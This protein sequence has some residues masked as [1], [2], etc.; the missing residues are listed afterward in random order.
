M[1]SAETGAAMRAALT[2]RCPRCG[3]GRLLRGL[4]T[5]EPACLGC[6]T[7]LSKHMAGDGGPYVLILVLGHLMVA[8]A[9]A[10][11]AAFAPPMWLHLTF[12]TAV[13][14]GL[15]LLLLPPVKRF[16]IAFSMMHG[17][18]EEDRLPPD[19]NHAVSATPSRGEI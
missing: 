2:N 9:V 3:E 11:E 19:E 13:T 5:P 14:V 1:F 8:G 10:L 12:A 15:S 6:R 7:D 17:E 18:D 16:L 4:L